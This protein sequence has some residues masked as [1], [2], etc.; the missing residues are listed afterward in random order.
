MVLFFAA[1]GLAVSYAYAYA[2]LLERF[3]LLAPVAQSLPK[4]A[5]EYQE[6]LE[7]L[8]SVCLVLLPLSITFAVV[9]CNQRRAVIGALAKGYWE[10]YLK[11]ILESTDTQKKIFVLIPTYA[12]V[13]NVPFYQKQIRQKL[14]REL[15]VQIEDR[16][17]EGTGRTGWILKKGGNETHA[18][19]DVCRN[20][21]TLGDILISE[22]RTRI[23]F[24]CKAEHKFNLLGDYFSK[25]LKSEYLKTYDLSHRVSVLPPGDYSSLRQELAGAIVPTVAPK[26][27]E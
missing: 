17:I 23:D 6:A 18:I 20:L 25:Y 27:A 3:P 9:V 12:I 26:T 22:S 7:A 21:T 19:C 4:L 16:L 11:A 13:N 14:E 15:E 8:N 10:N 2:Y 1:I 5:P 24:I